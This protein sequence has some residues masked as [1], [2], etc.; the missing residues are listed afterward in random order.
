MSPD[1]RIFLDSS[2]MI[3]GVWSAS[4]G[5]RELLR[6]GASG[7]IELIVSSQVLS[8]VEAVLRRKA[9]DLV[10]EM[11][12]LLERSHAQL[13]SSPDART[14]ARCAELARHAGDG[15]ILA[16]ACSAE[17]GFFVTLDRQHLLGNRMVAEQMQFPIGTP[18]DCIAWLRD[19]WA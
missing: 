7:A 10:S 19:L 12:L 16:D 11:A 17:V 6:L 9:P 2:A 4:A 13:V 15:R 8:E 3:A 14:I 5:S 1:P 18:G